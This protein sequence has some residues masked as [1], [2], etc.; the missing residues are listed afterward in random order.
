MIVRV[1]VRLKDHTLVDQ[2]VHATRHEPV[3]VDAAQRSM[4]FDVPYRRVEALLDRLAKC[5]GGEF[6]AHITP[7]PDTQ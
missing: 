5:G 3:T 7:T 1:E 4:A 2:F 6:L